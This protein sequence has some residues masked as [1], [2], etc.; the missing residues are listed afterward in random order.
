MKK[1]DLQGYFPF[2]IEHA[3]LTESGQVVNDSKADLVSF[4]SVLVKV[5]QPIR[6]FPKDEPT[7]I[8]WKS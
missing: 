3:I 5:Y 6:V 4:N 1:M 2:T 7:N 8:L